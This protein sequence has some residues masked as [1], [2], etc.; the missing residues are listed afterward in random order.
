MEENRKPRNRFSQ[1]N[2]GQPQGSI[3]N[4]MEEE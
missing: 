2:K 3:D 4:L 1:V